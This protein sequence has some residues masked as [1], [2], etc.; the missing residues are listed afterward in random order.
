IRDSII[1]VNSY[2]RFYLSLLIYK[3]FFNDIIYLLIY[4]CDYC[5]SARPTDL[6]IP[7]NHP[8]STLT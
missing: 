1:Y 5:S 3:N 2:E 4:L 7:F 8:Y 6:N